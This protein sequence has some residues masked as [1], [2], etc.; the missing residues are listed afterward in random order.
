MSV[1]VCIFLQDVLRISQQNE[2]WQK[3][4]AIIIEIEDRPDNKNK[5]AVVVSP[6]DKNIFL[7]Y[8]KMFP[9]FLFVKSLKTL[10]TNEVFLKH[11]NV[12]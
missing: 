8:I 10:G 12:M 7:S 4:T 9:H 11:N 5:F 6:K 3:A 2:W 1:V